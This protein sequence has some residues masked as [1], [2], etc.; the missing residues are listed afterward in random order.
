MLNPMHQAIISPVSGFSDKFQIR[1]HCSKPVYLKQ[2]VLKLLVF[3]MIIVGFASATQAQSKWNLV[4]CIDYALDN[5]IDVSISKNSV[6]TQQVNLQE[7]KADIFPNL[8]MGSEVNMNFG[9]NIDPN[10]NTVTF[11]QTMQNY[12]WVNTS[13]NLFQGFT[14]I[15][16]IRFNNF[17]LAAQKEES[18]LA[19]NQLVFKILTAYYTVLY[20]SGLVNVAK[21]QVLLSEKQIKRMQKFVETGRKSPLMIQELKSQRAN[22]RLSLTR[23]E[24][25]YSKTLLELKQL[26]RLDAGYPFETDTTGNLAVSLM[27]LPDVDSLY[28]EAVAVMPEIKQQ[29]MLYHALEKELAVAR[30]F[31][32]PR[33]YLSAGYATNFFNGSDMNF[34]RQLENNQNQWINMGIAIP[35]FNNA[36]VHSRIKRK[37]IETDNQKLKLEKQRETLYTQIWKAADELK[38]AENEYFSALELNNYSKL[39]LENIAKK[40][41]NGLAGTTD[42]DVAKQRYISAQATLLKAKLVYLMRKQMLEFYRKG[43]WNHL[44]V[45]QK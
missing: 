24:N 39:S 43:N 12:Y 42:Y 8:N 11:N 37:K 6:K 13:V 10:T 38:S 16:T 40:M 32:S 35:V 36:S 45:S 19:K 27:P 9:R 34:T 41:E 28:K 14:K 26:L 1:Q 29:Q 30:G 7:S 3:M 22:D 2:Y 20:S 5:N 15:N 17:L 18:Q 23:A 44:Y 33:V 25:F 21:S 31:R 4:R